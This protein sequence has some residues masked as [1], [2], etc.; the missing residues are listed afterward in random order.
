[1]TLNSNSTMNNTDPNKKTHRLQFVLAA[2]LSL[3]AFGFSS[4]I[5]QAQ[6]ASKAA[7]TAPARAARKENPVPADAKSIEQGKSFF[8]MAC[9]PCHGASGKGDGPS[10][11]TLERN[12][13]KIRPG[14][15]ADPKMWS[16]SDGAIFWKISEGNSPMPTFAQ[17]FTEEQ[18]WQIVD[19]VRTLAPRP[20][21]N[22]PETARK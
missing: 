12:G 8:N 22:S 13:V 16:Q 10:G 1:M 18:R 11:S 5:A 14:N 6:E 19:Y 20:A 9:F 15:L 4:G 21:G 3:T 7:W 2:T 17:T